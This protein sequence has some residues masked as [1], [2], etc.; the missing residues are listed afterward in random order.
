MQYSQSS[1]SSS[2]SSIKSVQ[3]V[4]PFPIPVACSNIQLLQ[5]QTA[6][7][8]FNFIYPSNI[9]PSIKDFCKMAILLSCQPQYKTYN[10]MARLIAD[11]FNER[12]SGNWGVSLIKINCGCTCFNSTLMGYIIQYNGLEYYIFQTGTGT[13]EANIPT[14]NNRNHQFV[15]A[16]IPINT[17]SFF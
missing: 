11:K 17:K 15:N 4:S 2:L 9:T 7:D 1:I 6:A 5:S 3:S 13:I 14:N 16:Q 8:A 10:D 12:F